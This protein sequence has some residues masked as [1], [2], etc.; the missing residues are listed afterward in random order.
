M[1]TSY[2]TRPDRGMPGLLFDLRASWIE[3]Y[4]AEGAIPFGR[5]VQYGTDA[6]N[7]VKLFAAAGLLAGV[8]V[9]THKEP[10]DDDGYEDEQAVGV[11]RK[12]VIW[13]EFDADAVGTPGKGDAV[14][15]I[16]DT[17]I[18]TGDDDRG[19]LC[20]GA[21]FYGEPVTFGSTPMVAIEIDMTSMAGVPLTTITN[22]T[23]GDFTPVAGEAPVLLL[24]DTQWTAKIEWNEDMD[25][26]GMF[27]PS[28]DYTCTVTVTPKAGYTLAGIGANT[29]VATGS[30]T[31]TNDADS[32]EVDVT[33][34]TTAATITAID[35]ETVV[36]AP[37]KGATAVET[38]DET[39]YTGTV[40]W[41]PALVG[42]GDDEFD[43]EEI[44]EAT[45][46]LTAKT[47][48]TLYGIE[49]DEFIHAGATNI[50][51]SANSGRVVATFPET[52]A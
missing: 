42:A 6:E 19:D 51:N 48:Y 26:N 46:T 25:G 2:Q 1:Q 52:S 22:L 27:K 20:Q 49:A 37:V 24:D 23:L 4:A 30:D 50:N 44:Y 45:I 9:H 15:V 17:G 5:F 12:G 34:A 10:G 38:I 39:Q 16:R 8:S 41:L 21:V 14:Y 31:D 47:G 43:A 29:W 18:A 32:G 40:V 13:I 7:Q 11:L 28:E 33:Y 36:V 3:S 35:L